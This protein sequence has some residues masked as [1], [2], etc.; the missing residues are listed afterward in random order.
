MQQVEWRFL[1]TNLRG[2]CEVWVEIDPDESADRDVAAYLYAS[3]ADGVTGT[4]RITSM[5]GLTKDDLQGLAGMLGRA[6]A[7]CGEIFERPWPY[8]SSCEQSADPKGEHRCTRE[9]VSAPV[10]QMPAPIDHAAHIEILDLSGRVRGA[11]WRRGVKTVG[12]LLAMSERDLFQIK[13]V[14]PAVVQEIKH[15]LA[16]RGW[17][18]KG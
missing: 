12:A 9:N 1:K 11:L 15:R 8:C 2:D 10:G 17:S 6:A 4:G 16:G 14:G 13:G 18:L 3:G 7:L 5:I